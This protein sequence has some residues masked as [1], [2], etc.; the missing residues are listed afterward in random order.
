MAFRL[1][2]LS[3]VP[4]VIQTVINYHNTPAKP[5]GVVTVQRLNVRS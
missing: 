2:N 3:T 5:C 1:W 4:D